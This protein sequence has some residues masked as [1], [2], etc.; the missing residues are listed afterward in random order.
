MHRFISVDEVQEISYF[1]AIVNW[2]VAPIAL[3]FVF[4]MLTEC[5]HAFAKEQNL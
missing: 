2:F 1:P 3:V 5:E 4:S